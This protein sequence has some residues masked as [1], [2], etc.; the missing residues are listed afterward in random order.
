MSNADKFPDELEFDFDK[1]QK[2]AFELVLNHRSG[3]ALVSGPAGS[4]KTEVS[5]AAAV[6]R[7]INDRKEAIKAGVP[8]DEY[9]DRFVI[10][11]ITNSATEILNRKLYRHW[12]KANDSEVE[13]FIGQE[14]SSLPEAVTTHSAVYRT[15]TK[16]P[17]ATL[18]KMAKE[19]LIGGIRTFMDP[20]Q[21][22]HWETVDSV[23]GK[24]YIPPYTDTWFNP[25]SLEQI[26]E[27][28]TEAFDSVKAGMGVREVLALVWAKAGIDTSEY[29]HLSPREGEGYTLF[30]DEAS[31][32]DSE[33][34]EN[35]K[36]VFDGVI[37]VGDSC[38]LPPVIDRQGKF[39]GV[40]AVLPSEFDLGKDQ[41]KKVCEALFDSVVI[42]DNVHRSADFPKKCANKIRQGGGIDEL[43][44][45][46]DMMNM[47]K[48]RMLNNPT[49]ENGY[50]YVPILV[51]TN[52]SRLLLTE[53]ARDARGYS[54]GKFEVGEMLI[55]NEAMELQS[56]RGE[57][58]YSFKKGSRFEIVEVPEKPD[59]FL[60]LRAINSI[61]G[62]DILYEVNLKNL[63]RNIEWGP[64]DIDLGSAALW[65][66]AYAITVHKAQGSEFDQVAIYSKDA[67]AMSRSNKAKKDFR[68]W[69]YTGMTRARNQI[70]WFG[71]I[72]N[73]VALE[74]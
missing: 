53:A 44:N 38:Q 4:G 41:H 68:P 60:I 32:L 43:L 3:L 37:L 8:W 45:E 57:E 22:S 74:E 1:K 16:E 66:F 46:L 67:A 51:W 39:D 56:E 6:N 61:Y 50:E 55:T 21:T 28:L 18:E 70:L 19:Y 7:I 33:L 12:T 17:F 42:L 27:L 34:F 10:S 14:Y 30:I 40:T 11:C 20:P 63:V 35:A 54:V 2:Q 47:F 13:S 65:R 52:A 26:V 25:K 49:E 36:A 9:R 5:A 59:G 23:T 64:A 48:G 29:M 24:V 62:R 71:S 69:L 58:R 15:T 73:R 31:M 72:G